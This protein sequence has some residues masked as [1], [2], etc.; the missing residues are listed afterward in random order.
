MKA[1]DRVKP[2]TPLEEQLLA[3]L[4]LC[5]KHLSKAASLCQR[6]SRMREASDSEHL[7]PALR[8]SLLWKGTMRALAALQ[9]IPPLK[10]MNPWDMP[11]KKPN[12]NQKKV[13]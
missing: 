9:A 2:E 3:E 7:A 5:E 11:V 6:I 4:A 1:F 13:T 8:V 10:K 12:E